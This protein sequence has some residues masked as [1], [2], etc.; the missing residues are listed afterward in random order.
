MHLK[1]E[2][3]LNIEQDA[4]GDLLP[5]R[6]GYGDD[7]RLSLPHERPRDLAAVGGC[8]EGPVRGVVPR[9]LVGAVRI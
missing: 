2:D 9:H 7:D 5:G 3:L 4:E 1:A 6:G 8:A